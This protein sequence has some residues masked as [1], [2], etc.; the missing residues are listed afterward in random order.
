VL[1]AGVR[2]VFSASSD[3]NPLVSGKGLNRLKRGGVAVVTHVLKDEADALNRPFFK[4]MR[5]G[6]P[7]VTL[8]A[9]VT[10]DGKIAAP[11]GDSKWVTGEASRAWVHR[12]RDQVDAIL[13]GANTVR[14]DDPQLTTRL[15]GGGG[16][17]PVRVVVDSHLKLSPG[18]T[19]FTQRSPAR[20]VIATLEDPEGR[21][22]RR[23]LAQ[24]VEVWNVRAKQDRVDLKAVLKRVKKEG[25]NHVLV[26]GGAGL[27]GTLL[28][29]H[30]ADALALFVAPKLVGAGGLSWAGELGVKDMAHALAVKDLMMEKVGDDVLLRALL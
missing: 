8:K 11:S 12:L 4:M 10:L 24:G 5:T 15:P 2:R 19:V 20:T 30:L 3:P 1:E 29:E 28:R 21:R 18:H 25:L 26:E 22:A 7:W 13:V 9:A 23:F 6:L 16:K 17:D 14:M 27:Y